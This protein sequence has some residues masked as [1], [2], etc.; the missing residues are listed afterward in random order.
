MVVLAC[1]WGSQAQTRA[2]MVTKCAQ[3]TASCSSA[4]NL[5]YAS[6]T[7]RNTPTSLSLTGPRLNSRMARRMLH[8]V[9]N[10]GNT[11]NTSHLGAAAVAGTGAEHR[12]QGGHGEAGRVFGSGHVAT[13]CI[14]DLQPSGPSTTQPAARC[15]PADLAQA[16]RRRP[17]GGGGSCHTPYALGKGV[18]VHPYRPCQP[19][20]QRSCHTPYALGKGVVLHP[21]RPCQPQ[22][23]RS[24][25][26][27]ATTNPL[28]QPALVR[29]AQPHVGPG[30]VGAAGNFAPSL[31]A[32]WGYAGSR[33]P[34]CPVLPC[35]QPP[36]LTRLYNPATAA[37]I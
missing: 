21:Y 20:T 32:L 10:T 25:S 13:S 22:T 33:S 26:A 14:P 6:H 36:A 34:S 28:P 24:C 9:Q 3:T 23:Q 27:A 29:T 30:S 15:P 8:E 2:C 12:K 35:S 17:R 31:P 4:Q 1:T 5:Q 16:Q 11:K 18:V 37:A 19:Q 7:C